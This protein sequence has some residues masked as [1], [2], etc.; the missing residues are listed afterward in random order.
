MVS[1]EPMGPGERFIGKMVARP[2]WAEGLNERQVDAVL[3]VG[4]H[5]RIT[6]G[7][8]QAMSGV[9]DATA[10]RDLKALCDKGLL[11]RRGKGRGT[12]YALA[13]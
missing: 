1:T 5:G 11:V 10:Y 8:Y 7:E 3:Y 9:S 13:G 6:V 12:R 4:E 2:A